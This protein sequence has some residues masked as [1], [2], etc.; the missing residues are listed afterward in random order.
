M[1]NLNP[2]C[3]EMRHLFKII[4]YELTQVF[5]NNPHYLLKGDLKTVSVII[6]VIKILD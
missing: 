4:I 6:T 2:I 5:K 3:Q 1:I